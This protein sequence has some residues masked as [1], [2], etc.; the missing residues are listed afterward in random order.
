MWG[1]C[2]AEIPQNDPATLFTTDLDQL[3]QQVCLL[4]IWWDH[5]DLNQEPSGYEPGA[6]NQLS[7]GPM[8]GAPTRIRT[9]NRSLEDSYD[10]PFTIGA[11]NYLLSP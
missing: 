4:L 8:L 10:I 2:V 5:L 9:W 7:Y 1:F 6:A 11:M 3:V